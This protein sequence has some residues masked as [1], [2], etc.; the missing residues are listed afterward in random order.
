MEEI[1][2]KLYNNGNISLKKYNDI[3]FYYNPNFRMK[4][5]YIEPY[6]K[7]NINTRQKNFQ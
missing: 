1:C 3:K 7:R 2:Q 6:K 5:I 4:Y